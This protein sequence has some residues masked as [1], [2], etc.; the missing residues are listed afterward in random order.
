MVVIDPA[1]FARRQVRAQLAPLGCVVLELSGSE[2]EPVVRRQLQ[3]AR[4]VLAEPAPWGRD[5]GRWLA[6]LKAMNPAATLVVCTALTTRAAVVAYRRAG[7]ADVVAKPWDPARLQA[8]V[9]FALAARGPAGRL[10]PRA[11]RGAATSPGGE[12]PGRACQ[13]AGPVQ[14]ETGGTGE[15]CGQA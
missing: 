5:A 14:G 7:A 6:A 15:P 12:S 1:A 9:R 10:D 4:V 13:G 2:P 3:R 8:A 11:S